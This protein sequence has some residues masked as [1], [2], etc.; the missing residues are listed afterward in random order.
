MAF[1][2]EVKDCFRFVDV[3]VTN[4]VVPCALLLFWSGWVAF[5]GKRLENVEG[6]EGKTNNVGSQAFQ[7]CA[8]R[9]CSR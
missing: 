9:A 5:G 3:W 2:E 4:L 8:C 1:T 7:V 6:T